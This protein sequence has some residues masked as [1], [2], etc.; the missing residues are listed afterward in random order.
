MIDHVMAGDDANMTTHHGVLMVRRHADELGM[1]LAVQSVHE[2][3]DQVE[4]VLS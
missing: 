3:G 4:N 1:P 2:L